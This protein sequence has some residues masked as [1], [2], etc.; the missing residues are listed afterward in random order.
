[1]AD[2]DVVKILNVGSRSF[3]LGQGR[4]LAP[5]KIMS[6]PAVEAK[7]LLNYKDLVDASK[8]MESGPDPEVAALK[9]ENAKLA[10][11]VLDLKDQ[12]KD[13]KKK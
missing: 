3:N 1:M 9:A 13:A 11:Q 6:V 10:Q 5:K 8:V 12:L 4:I 2:A 7:K